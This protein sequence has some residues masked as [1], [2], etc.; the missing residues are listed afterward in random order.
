M[1]KEEKEEEGQTKKSP[2]VSRQTLI[3]HQAE[4]L[5]TAATQVI[6]LCC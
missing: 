6:I 4:T 5:V 3:A 1:E 2:E